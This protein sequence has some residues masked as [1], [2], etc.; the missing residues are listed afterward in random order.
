MGSP[1]RQVSALDDGGE[2]PKVGHL[3][4]LLPAHLHGLDQ[5]SQV[6]LCQV[7][8]PKPVNMPVIHPLAELCGHNQQ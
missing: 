7:G 4:G 8:Q 5:I 3:G 1:S 2:L 6:D